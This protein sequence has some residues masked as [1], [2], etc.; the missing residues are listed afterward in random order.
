MLKFDDPEHYR[1]LPPIILQN[2]SVL[3]SNLSDIY[4]FHEK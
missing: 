2:K 4:A 3:F 1:Y